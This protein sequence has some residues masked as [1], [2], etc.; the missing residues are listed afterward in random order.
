MGNTMYG[1][2]H[3]LDHYGYKCPKDI[4]GVYISLT[5]YVDQ[6]ILL[7]WRMRNAYL[8]WHCREIVVHLVSHHIQTIILK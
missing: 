7:G 1:T 2:K 5:L 3:T 4:D 6:C 8:M